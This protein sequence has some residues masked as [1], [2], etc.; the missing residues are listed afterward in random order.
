MKKVI[1]LLLSVVTIA[2]CSS[3]MTPV[4]AVGAD[5]SVNTSE[6]VTVS[7]VETRFLNVLNHNFVY[8]S[9][10][11]NADTVVNNSILAILNLRDSE[12]QDYIA[13]DYV[14]NFVKDMYG[15]EI[16]DMSNL[17]SEFPHKDGYLYIVPRGYTTYTHKIVSVNQND[18]GSYTVVSD[19]TVKNHDSDA[20]SQKAV[21][22]FVKNDSSAFG[23]NMIYCNI[24]ENSLDV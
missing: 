18:D 8:N 7:A 2:L 19:I 21:S 9:D 3:L 5:A 20:K 4:V 1:V 11:E 16:V 13:E 10:F 6:S 24:I 22:L 12:D 15:I 23:Y 14:K 17:N